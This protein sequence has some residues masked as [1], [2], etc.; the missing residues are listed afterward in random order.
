TVTNGKMDPRVFL[1]DTEDSIINVTGGVNLTDEEL[2]LTIN[3]RSK[4][5]RIFSLRSPIY[6]KGTFVK[7]DIDI[8]KRV[9]A[10]KAGG[11]VALAV[12]AP[13]ATALLPL[14]NLGKDENSPC[15]ALLAQASEKPQAP[16]P[17][18]TASGAKAR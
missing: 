10:M 14:A 17:G 15:Q 3:P 9:L 18:K 1:V 8:D 4:G 6:V 16:P 13:V 2:G 7:P 11:A 5:L 12:V